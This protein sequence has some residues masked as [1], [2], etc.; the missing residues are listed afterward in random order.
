MTPLSPAT[1]NP[2]PTHVAIAATMLKLEGMGKPSKYLDLPVAS[3]GREETVTLKR[4]RRVRPQR[5]K[6]ERRRVS[7]GVRR[8]R[9]KA[10]E[11]G[12][13]PKEI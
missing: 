2:I 10:Q 13:T 12:A 6:K 5:T 3:L 9:A 8:P 1:V 7:R 11:A 4:A